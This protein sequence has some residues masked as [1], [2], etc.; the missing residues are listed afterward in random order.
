MDKSQVR[1][2]WQLIGERF[3][4]TKGH[5]LYDVPFQ[6]KDAPG[7]RLFHLLVHALSWGRPWRILDCGCA[8]GVDFETFSTW[9]NI[10][11]VGMDWT[12][13]FIRTAKER[14]GYGAP[15]QIGS[16][17]DIPFKSQA[18]HLVYERH[19]LEH[20]PGLT[21]VEQAITEMTRVSKEWLA[22][23]FAATPGEYNVIRVSDHG[24]IDLPTNVYSQDF[25]LQ[26]LAQN[27]F[28]R[29]LSLFESGDTIYLCRRSLS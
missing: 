10:D 15:F 3:D 18:F 25:I 7:R 6:D 11:Y 16:I 21:E 22:L 2:S 5:Y 27:R 29:V 1:T 19:V 26:V 24:G 12:E 28:S 9:P 4:P 13:K 23:I 20:L 17:L 14:F 8:T